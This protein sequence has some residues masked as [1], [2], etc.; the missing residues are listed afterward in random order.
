MTTPARFDI[1][2]LDECEALARLL[3][4][5]ASLPLTIGLVGTLG[6]GKTQFT[7]YLAVACGV[8]PEAIASPTFTLVHHYPGHPDL[9][10]LDAFRVKS[11]DEF[12]DL[13]V[14]ELFVEPAIVAVEW[15]DRF[16]E[17]LPADRLQLEFQFDGER[18]YVVANGLG[19]TSAVLV[20]RV[21]QAWRDRKT[22]EQ[23]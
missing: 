23:S 17:C 8:P 7:R 12:Y 21:A 16:A 18:R 10:H 6:A 9:Y 13:G 3:P 22:E 15:A 2:T 1:S 19:P 4:R 11:V 5:F 20:D 14:D